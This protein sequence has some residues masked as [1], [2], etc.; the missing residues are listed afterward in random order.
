MLKIPSPSYYIVPGEEYIRARFMS[1]C[2]RLRNAVIDNLD[3]ISKVKD[4]FR[5]CTKCLAD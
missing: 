2:P 4:V 5:A 3:R 1:V